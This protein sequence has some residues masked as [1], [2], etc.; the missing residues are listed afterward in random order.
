[1][2]LHERMPPPTAPP[3]APVLIIDDDEGMRVAMR[4]ALEEEGYD[5]DTAVDGADGLRKLRDGCRPRVI[6]LDH[7]MPNMDGA[8]FMHALRGDNT[9]PAFPVILVTADGRAETKSA[10]LGIRT[11]L[12]KPVKIDA[13]LDAIGR[14]E[15]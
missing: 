7:M 8:A 3:S 9:L 6:L 1:M 4:D 2:S 5:V 10:A 12:T 11:W 13:L 15:S 14:A